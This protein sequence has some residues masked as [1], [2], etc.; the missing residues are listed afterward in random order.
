MRVA[1]VERKTTETEVRARL[2]VDGNGRFQIETGVGFLDHLL[3]ALAFHALFDLEIEADGDLHVDNHHTVEDCAMILGRTLD[4]ALQ[5]RRGLRRFASIHLPMDEALAFVAVDVSGRPYAVVQAE[6]NG[7]SIGGIASS[8]ISH[9]LESFAFSARLTVHA[10]VLYGR[11]DH[12][13]SEAL[14]KALG[15][16]LRSACSI[17]QKR[18]NAV[19]STK[20]TL[21]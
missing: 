11:D 20:G 9:F 17:E 16:A 18:S 15:V 1:E 8:L 19:A 4:E 6:W 14:F 2:N 7:P 21:T 3:G 5:E 10:S 13:K 12:H